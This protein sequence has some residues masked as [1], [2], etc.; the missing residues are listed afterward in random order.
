MHSSLDRD[1]GHA[2]DMMLR[3]TLT[4][5][6]CTRSGFSINFQ[7]STEFSFRRFGGGS[8]AARRVKFPPANRS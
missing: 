1:R 5:R 2:D 4:M 8:R 7:A 6:L 3:N